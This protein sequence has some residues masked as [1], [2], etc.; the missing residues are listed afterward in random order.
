MKNNVA[1]YYQNLR[2]L[3]DAI[4]ASSGYYNLGWAEKGDRSSFNLAQERLVELV[5][6]RLNITP[7]MTVLD[8]G[9]GLG[10]PL[11]YASERSN[12]RIMGLEFLS[13]QI[14]AGKRAG[15]YSSANMC[16]SRGDAVDMPFAAS[17]FDRIYSIE[18]AF[19]YARKKNFVHE[20][21]R[22]LKP[23][24]I[25]AV[26]DIVISDQKS[27]NSYRRFRNS[28][29]SPELFTAAAYQNA[30]RDAGFKSCDVID[31]SAGV[32]ASVQKIGVDILK[33]PHIYRSTGI[34]LIQQ[35]FLMISTLA[36]KYVYRLFP[37]R[38]QLFMMKK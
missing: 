33:H 12:A 19:H 29:A 35:Y 10:G 17:S 28:L 16:L 1:N 13:S 15:A 26:A 25:L 3:F 7:E 8:C 32:M 4:S 22:T 6:D 36:L 24:G 2:T 27:R 5:I 38:Y 23:N 18:S 14:E 30:A 11:R 31:L 34:P 20:A 37:I 21:G 9:C